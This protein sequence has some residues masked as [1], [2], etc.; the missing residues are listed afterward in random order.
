MCCAR[1]HRAEKKKKKGVVG[2]GGV[3]SV[4][5]GGGCSGFPTDGR[6]LLWVGL[7]LVT[8]WLP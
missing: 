5:L 1:A 6:S 4:L 2:V 7:K 8:S 3:V